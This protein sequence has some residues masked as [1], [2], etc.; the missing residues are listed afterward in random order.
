[1]ELLLQE[2]TPTRAP[3][4]HPR[5]QQADAT[6]DAFASIPLDPWRVS[7]EAPYTQIHCLSNGNYSLLIS[8]AGSGFSRWKDIELTRWHDDPTLNERGSWIYVEDRQN[9][10]LWSVTQQPTM[11]PP[12]RSE[13]NFYPHRVEFERQDG[14]IVLRTVVSV[15]ANDN[16]EIRHV[17]MTNHG[18]TTRRLAL[19]SYAEVILSPQSVDQR[20]PAYNK[21]F[22]E[23][24]F[25]ER[26]QLLLFRRRPRSAEEE[27]IYLAH[28]FTGDRE[29]IHLASYETDREKFL[30]RGGTVRRPAAFS[31]PNR[32]SALSGTTGAT[33]DPVCALQVEVELAPYQTS[34]VAFI[35]LA[36]HS[37]KEAIDLARRNRRWSQLGPDHAGGSLP[38]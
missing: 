5:H 23:S 27:P 22:I 29:Q 7:P 2:Q 31:V 8:A 35:S 9:G 26:E 16:V 11:T 34:Q 19:T 28:F 4:E 17:N 14:E 10:R 20:H 33:L 30:G 3:T 18:D 6:R 25:V 13:V 1:V 36:A 15:A 38:G 24:E 37:R 21:L 32:V 12:D